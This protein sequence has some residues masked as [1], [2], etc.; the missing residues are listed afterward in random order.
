MDRS[1]ARKV[2]CASSFGAGANGRRRHRE[3]QQRFRLAD[4]SLC[5]AAQA[6]GL[7]VDVALSKLCCPGCSL[8]ARCK[9]CVET[10]LAQRD[11]SDFNP[12]YRSGALTTKRRTLAARLPLVV[13][14]HRHL[15]SQHS[16]S[17]C[18]GDKRSQRWIT[19]AAANRARLSSAKK[20]KRKNAS[21]NT[22]RS[23]RPRRRPRRRSRSNNRDRRRRP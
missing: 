8:A 14:A 3:A 10:A 7:Q 11:T 23:S 21:S 20:L 4:R 16:V 5:C 6:I 9:G 13:A 19:T 17:P 12:R 15:H 1:I 2:L 18:S 22:S